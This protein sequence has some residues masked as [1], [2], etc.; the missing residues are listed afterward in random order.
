VRLPKRLPAIGLRTRLVAALVATAAATL[1]VAALALLSPLEHRLRNEEVRFLAQ[2]ARQSESALRDLDETQLVPQSRALNRF[3]S[4]LERRTGARVLLFDDARRILVD[5]DPDAPPNGPEGGPFADVREAVDTGRRSESTSGAGAGGSARIAQPVSLGGRRYVIAMRGSL[6]R[7]RGAVRVV[8]DALLTAAIVGLAIASALGL[9][10]ATTLLRR[11][12]RLRDAA[13]RI[14]VEGL[15]PDLPHETRRDEVGELARALS[16]MQQRLRQQENARRAFVATASHELRTP[17][18]SLGALLE[19][20]EDDLQT[21]PADVKDAAP[22]VASAREQTRRL[23]GLANDLLELTRLDTG[24]QLRTELVE[25]HEISRAVIA[26]FG[27][28]AAEH[29]VSLELE[30][31]AACWVL[32]DPGA[33]ARIAR[34][35]VDNALRFGPSGEP[36]TVEVSNAGDRAVLAVHD[37][38]P[39]VPADERD[40]I[41]ERFRRG[42]DVRTEGGFGL[43]LAIGHE[44]AERMGGELVLASS[45]AGARFEL[46]LASAPSPMEDGAEAKRLHAA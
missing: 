41:F 35:L 5:T 21:Q 31:E 6:V 37:R 22:R 24:F 25:L 45:E 18:A 30:C 9:A 27:T 11:L 23:I 42:S 40:L 14:S 28:R 10:L 32:G 2:S 3:A 19:L 16:A 33:I 29:Q 12:R 13:S 36:I 38:G 7:T 26:E 43:G 34:I 1:A 20:V 8:R 44:L 4:D 15:E 46:R 17:L 39:G